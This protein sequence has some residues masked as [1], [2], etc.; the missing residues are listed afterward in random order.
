MKT[1]RGFMINS[2]TDNTKARKVSA[3]KLK[4]V[5][6]LVL[7]A[8]ARTEETKGAYPGGRFK[9]YFDIMRTYF[10]PLI[11]TNML[12]LLFLL[13]IVA[14]AFFFEVFGYESFGYLIANLDP[15]TPPYLMNNIGIGLSDGLSIMQAKSM[16]LSSYKVMAAGIAVLS[17]I[18]GIGIAGNI[19]ICTKLVW[20]ESFIM[21]KDKYGND[22][23]RIVTE[24][25]R[26]VKEFSGKMVLNVTIISVLVIGSILLV[27]EFVDSL[28]LGSTHAG[29][30]I[31]L[32]LGIIIALF[33]LMVSVIYLPFSVSYSSSNFKIKIK[34]SILL[35]LAFPLSTLII[36][37]LAF[38][39]FGLVFTG[40]MLKILVT[41]LLLSFGFTHACLTMTNYADYNSENIIQPLYQQ[42]IKTQIRTERKKAKVVEKQKKQNYKKMKKK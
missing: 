8:E 20:G 11:I 42:Q 30:Y 19:Y 13:P 5:Q 38:I 32:I 3:Y 10:Q 26:G 2:A 39:P 7:E 31:G 23:P 14:W 21:K 16:L 22:V 6:S 40:P 1:S 37:I 25:F 12:T 36:V 33:T 41:V 24:F 17:P 29:H 34:N 28:L 18:A 35:A 4:L 27:L 9:R 15:K